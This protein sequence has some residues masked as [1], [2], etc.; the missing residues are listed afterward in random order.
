MKLLHALRTH[1]ASMCSETWLQMWA[2]DEQQVFFFYFFLH[3]FLKSCNV[4]HFHCLGSSPTFSFR[5]LQT[6]GINL[7]S[8]RFPAE[9][10]LSHF[11]AYS[12]GT[13]HTS[14][15]PWHPVQPPP[16]PP[17]TEWLEH[18]H[19]LLRLLK[20]QNLC[21]TE[22]IRGH[23]SFISKLNSGYTRSCQR[24]FLALQCNKAFLNYRLI[25]H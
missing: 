21:R 16:P 13:G 5:P 1:C 9:S 14:G 8:H 11:F 18:F 2:A 24:A 25:T 3:A 12:D 7:G 22:T 20:Q 23:L 10:Q 19:W 4:P 6:G 17:W 15:S